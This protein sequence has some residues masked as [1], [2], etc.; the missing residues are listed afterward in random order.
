MFGIQ[1]GRVA[2]PAVAACCVAVG[3]ASHLSAVSLHRSAWSGSPPVSLVAAQSLIMTG[4]GMPEVTPEWMNFVAGNFIAPT[5]GDGFVNIPVTTPAEFWPFTGSGSLTLDVSTRL[6]SEILDAGLQAVIEANRVSGH[7]GDP[8]VVFGYSQ[9]AWIAAVE[10]QI[11][12]TRVAAGEILPPIDFVMLANPVRPNGGLFSRLPALSAVTW[13]PVN[14]APTDTS[15]R[16]YDI[17]RQYDPFA[18]FPR[19]PSN[20][21]AVVNAAFGLVNHD[22]STVTLDPNDPRYDP[23]TVV[24]QYGDTTYYLIPSKLP[25]LEPLRQTGFG[26][27][28]DALEPVL[29][30]IVESGYDRTTPYGQHTPAL[31]PSAAAVEAPRVA[32]RTDRP[33]LAPAASRAAAPVHRT[34]KVGRSRR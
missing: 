12:A 34:E 14:S 3:I 26:Q 8:I 22:Y 13:T 4:S 24:Q 11:L 15:F 32:T 16:T 21:L 23:N 27:V 29:T 20:V 28:A 1:T 7:P 2:C 33:A 18:D 25:M 5:A 10:K 6:G 9:S 31:T 19:D 30:P 17:A